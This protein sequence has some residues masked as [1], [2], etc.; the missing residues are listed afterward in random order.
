MNRVVQEP[1]HLFVFGSTLVLVQR[2][3]FHGCVSISFGP[4][5]TSRA[6]MLLLWVPVHSAHGKGLVETPPAEGSGIDAG[7][8]LPERFSHP[9]R[10]FPCLQ[11]F[12]TELCFVISHSLSLPGF[13]WTLLVT[14]NL[15]NSKVVPS[16]GQTNRQSS[17]MQHEQKPFKSIILGSC[18]LDVP[19]VSK[20]PGNHAPST[21]QTIIQ[22]HSA[23]SAC[24][25]TIVQSQKSTTDGS[26]SS[27]SLICS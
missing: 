4:L 13:F 1:M 14:Q 9:L 12:V 10:T 24:L 15:A 8:I 21:M 3:G 17:P 25:G 2:R 11:A 6:L 16:L 19:I 26:S 22:A 23:A 27:A 5:T 18:H 7:C 20:S